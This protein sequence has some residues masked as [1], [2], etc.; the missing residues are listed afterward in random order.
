MMSIHTRTKR[1]TV[2]QR[3]AMKGQQ[4]IVSLTTYTRSIAT[5]VDPLVDFILVGDSTAM[6]GYG[7]A[8]TLSMQ[9]VGVLGRRHRH[10][11]AQALG[12]L[13]Q[14]EEF[15]LALRRAGLDQLKP[16]Q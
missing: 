14:G 1:T 16:P 5:V 9:R 4:K 2:P 6:V 13:A 10:R 12:Q 7:R 11:H 8:S 15:T 3:V